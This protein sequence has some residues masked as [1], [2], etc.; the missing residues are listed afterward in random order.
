MQA[1]LI[2]LSLT[3]IIMRV[4]YWFIVENAFRVGQAKISVKIR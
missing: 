3:I 4:L 1:Y 2:A